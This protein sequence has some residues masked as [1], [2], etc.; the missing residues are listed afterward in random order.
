MD[1]VA[2][3]AYTRKR[4]ALPGPLHRLMDLIAIVSRPGGDS[5]VH[6][7]RC[8]ECNHDLR[9]TVWHNDLSP[10]NIEAL[11]RDSVCAGGLEIPFRGSKP[12]VNCN[13]EAGRC[14]RS[15]HPWLEPWGAHGHRMIL[16]WRVPPPSDGTV[17]I[18][19]LR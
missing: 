11:L 19:S 18:S 9:L 6:I 3:R 4:R 17:T 12:D 16:I 14:V 7:F 10:A 1:V 15:G 5:E 2:L 8:P 13:R